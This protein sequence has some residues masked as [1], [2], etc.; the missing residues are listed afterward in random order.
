MADEDV[1]NIRDG[2]R[3][4]NALPLH[5]YANLYLDARN[6]MMFKRKAFSEKF[7]LL[8]VSLNVL[9]IKGVVVSDGNAAAEMT[10]FGPP[11]IMIG[12][13]R[14]EYDKIFMR[15]WPV[16]DDIRETRENKRKKCAEVLVP[17][18]ID[19]DNI[20]GAIVVNKQVE[21]DLKQKGFLKKIVINPDLFFK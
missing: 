7:I 18:K 4:P 1:Q 2:K 19:Y 16:A 14:L 11:E 3:V 12:K 6:P 13:D 17:H 20:L 10:A 21:N 5:D 8:V 9:R 15:H